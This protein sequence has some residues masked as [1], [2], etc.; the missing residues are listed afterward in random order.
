MSSITRSAQF[1]SRFL[2]IIA[3]TLVVLVAGVLVTFAPL[4]AV[5]SNHVNQV[6][7]PAN[8][9]DQ[10]QPMNNLLLGT[11]SGMAGTVDPVPLTVEFLS[12]NT[13]VAT[14][15][16][17]TS[18]SETVRGTYKLIADNQIEVILSTPYDVTEKLSFTLNGDT[19]TLRDQQQ[20]S[21]L[22]TRVQQ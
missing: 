9:R 7:L 16:P 22:L 4:R 2:L 18:T 11:W 6:T 1:H 12:D 15:R 13:Y 10:V 8:Q 5:V 3:A 20:V 14:Q 17:N 21:M 19:L